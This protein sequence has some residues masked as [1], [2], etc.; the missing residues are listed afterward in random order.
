NPPEGAM[1]DY[2]LADDA[3]GPVTLEIQDRQGQIVRRYSSADPVAA[4]DPAK[5]KVPMYW[6]RPPQ[7]LSAKQGLHRLF[8]DIHYEPIP[9]VEPE[10]PIAAVPH[11]TAP[12]SSG[13]WAAPGEYSVVLTVG[14]EKFKQPLQVKMDPRVKAAD[15]DLAAQFDLSRKLYEARPALIAIDKEL[16]VASEKIAKAKEA[17]EGKP[18]QDLLTAF[19]KKLREFGAKNA[20]SYAPFRLEALGHLENLFGTLQGVDA[21]PTPRVAA[22]VPEVLQEA[23]RAQE[24]W[25]IFL[26]QDLPALNQL[27]EAAGLAKL[28]LAE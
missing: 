9:G 24:R 17:A 23:T 5:V 7:A 4:P 10:Y 13:M 28:S 26:T 2:Q 15:A 25:R 18:A 1:I 16:T 12:E 8:W 21:G 3:S 20:P 19:Q 11:Q 14:A 22:A 6:L 27:L